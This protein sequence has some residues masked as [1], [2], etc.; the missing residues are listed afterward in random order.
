MKK[1]ARKWR[2]APQALIDTFEA[3]LRNF[4]HIAQRHMFGYPAAFANG[5]LFAGLFENSVILKLPAEA[6][7][8]LL[9]MPG[10]SRFEPM[11]GRVIGEFVVVP[12]SVVNNSARLIQWLKLACAYVESFPPKTTKQRIGSSSKPRDR[13]ARRSR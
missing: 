8:K 10:A 13:P 11:P 6:R 7:S 3:C 9:K 12:P 4:P 1:K 5:Y 2:P